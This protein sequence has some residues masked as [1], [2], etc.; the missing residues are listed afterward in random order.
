MKLLTPVFAFPV[1]LGTPLLPTVTVV[2]DR[3]RARTDAFV[4]RNSSLGLLVLSNLQLRGARVSLNFLLLIRVNR[5]AGKVFAL[6]VQ[7]AGTT[8]I[9]RSVLK[10]P[11]IPPTFPLSPP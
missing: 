3:L 4:L 10:I 7:V 1:Q 6:A 8:G 9:A 11:K 5:S 2:P